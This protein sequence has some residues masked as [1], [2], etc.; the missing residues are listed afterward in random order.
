M[1]LFVVRINPDNS[2]MQFDR[3]GNPSNLTK[4]YQHG[5]VKNERV[6]ESLEKRTLTTQNG[7]HEC[8]N[9]LA[10][11]GEIQG[12]LPPGSLRGVGVGEHFSVIFIT[13]KGNGYIR[14]GGRETNRLVRSQEKRLFSNK[15]VGVQVDC[16]YHGDGDLY[17]FT[18]AQWGGDTPLIYKYTCRAEKSFLFR[19]SLDNAAEVLLG[20]YIAKNWGSALGPS[21]EILDDNVYFQDFLRS[22]EGCFEKSIF[23]VLNNDSKREKLSPEV[24]LVDLSANKVSNEGRRFLALHK[25]IERNQSLVKEAKKRY[26]NACNGRTPCELCGFDFK[27]LYKMLHDEFYIE[28]HHI[29]PLADNEADG[30]QTDAE[31]DFAFLCANCHRMVHRHLAKL[32][33]VERRQETSANK[34][35]VLND[36]RAKLFKS[37]KN[38]GSHK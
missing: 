25:R 5:E 18:E 9:F 26:K 30:R 29:R 36:Y 20:P 10:I 31:K 27:D 13:N 38:K 24:D 35:K 6:Y 19:K 7:F 11:N 23:D 12:Y 16:V 28:A 22:C 37:P 14:R 1:R 2:V 21:Q 4:C 34:K 15:I 32:S 33:E 8:Q 17:K 3:N